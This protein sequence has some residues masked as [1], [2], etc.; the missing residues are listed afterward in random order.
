MLKGLVGL[1]LPGGA[2]LVWA[3]LSRRLAIVPEALL[4]GAARSSSS[5][6]S[7]RGTSPSRGA[8][9]SGSTSTSSASTSGGTSR[10]GTGERGS[11]PLRLW[12]LLG[13]LLPWTPFLGRLAGAFPSIR[14]GEWRER[15]AEAYLQVFW[16]LVLLFFSASQSKL[17]PY[18]LPVWPAVAVLVAARPREGPAAGGAAPPGAMGL[19]PPLRPSRRA[20]SRPT[21]S[22]RGWRP[23]TGSGPEAVVRD[24]LPRPRGAPEPPP[25][26]GRLPLPAPARLD[27][28]ARP[29]GRRRRGS[30]SSRRSSSPCR[31]SPV[32]SR[33]GRSWPS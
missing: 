1:V 25:G 9:A 23:G 22:G 11:P 29:D 13:G 31:P 33:P 18:I 32:P 5:P 14:R 12:A 28:T 3:L 10:A 19:G 24:G 21:P 16:I 7:C 2:I 30:G 6:S 26:P 27:G 20:S 4:A 17:V 15:G 8:T